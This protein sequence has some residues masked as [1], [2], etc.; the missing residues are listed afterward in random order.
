MEAVVPWLD[1]AE[2]E[3]VGLSRTCW[4]ALFVANFLPLML[5]TTRTRSTW[6]LQRWQEGKRPPS[7]WSRIDLTSCKAPLRDIDL[8]NGSASEAVTCVLNLH[9]ALILE[10]WLETQ[11]KIAHCGR[12][13]LQFSR[14]KKHEIKTNALYDMT[15]TCQLLLQ[16]WGHP[17][18]AYIYIY[19]ARR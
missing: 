7:L 9:H 3:A 16:L 1:Q 19:Q 14:E 17:K 18:M 8:P 15:W 12:Q 2:D 5:P 6:R 10:N 11:C 4:S 13:L